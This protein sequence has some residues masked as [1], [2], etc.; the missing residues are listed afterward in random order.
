MVFLRVFVVLA[1]ILGCSLSENNVAANPLNRLEQCPTTL[2]FA[3]AIAKQLQSHYFNTNSGQYN[4][5]ELWTD[6]NTLEDLHN[7]MLATGNDDFGTVADNSYLGRA[8]LNSGTDWN[9]FLGGS[10][11]DAQWCILALWKIADYKAARGQDNTPYI[12]SAAAIYKIVARE[13]DTTTCGGGVWWSSAHSYKNAITNELFLFTSASGYLR[14]QDQMYLD[15]ANKEWAWLSASGMGNSDGLYN[16]GLNSANPAACT[17]NG[18]TTWTYNQGVI[19]SGLAALSVATGDA[20]LLDQAEI[21]LDATISHLTVN[22]ILKE[23]CDDAKAGGGQCDYDQQIFKGIWTKHLRYY[24]DYA[25][26]ATRT[27]KYSQFLG[28]QY[29]AILHHSMDADHDIGS[30]WYASDQGGSSWSPES[31][32]SGL[33][34]SIADA[35]YG[36]C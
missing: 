28:S 7:L 29:S 13:W 15:N 26:D 30:V 35:K 4:D 12:N 31:S 2:D 5:G 24:L 18:Q 16:D 1:T 20:S 21:T 14:T 8:A 9:S 17:N 23:S 22:D 19:A 34:A 6:A 3:E 33:A 27:A 36:P 11:D 10:Y 32:A 25:D